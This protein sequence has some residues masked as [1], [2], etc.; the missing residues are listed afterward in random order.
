MKKFEIRL[1]EQHRR[2]ALH[3]KNLTAFIENPERFNKLA[4]EDQQLIQ[5]QQALMARLDDVL[6]QR[7]R[8]LNIPV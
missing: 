1:A 5:T 8:R 2:N 3:L 7:L 4:P 6:E